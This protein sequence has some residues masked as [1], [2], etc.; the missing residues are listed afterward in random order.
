[1]WSHCGMNG[2]QAMPTEHGPKRLKGELVGM[3]SFCL[4]E[5]YTRTSGSF[6]KL[7]WL[8]EKCR[9][10]EACHRKELLEIN[11]LES[12]ENIIWFY[13]VTDMEQTAALNSQ[14]T[15]CEISLH[16]HVSVVKL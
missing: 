5:K 14:E 9:N 3:Q 4:M 13:V 16:K 1:M 2:T 6:R 7:F 8:G 15:S 10:S 11:F 12:P